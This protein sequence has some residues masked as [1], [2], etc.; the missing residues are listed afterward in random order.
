MPANMSSPWPPAAPACWRFL[1]I[2]FNL[3]KSVSPAAGSAAT[4]ASL[5]L[6][7]LRLTQGFWAL[8]RPVRARTVSIRRTA[9]V[10]LG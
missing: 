10:S 4:G 8:V 1:T 2:S 7:F 6:F 9:M 3:L 5:S